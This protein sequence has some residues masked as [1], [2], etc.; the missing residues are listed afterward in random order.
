MW[1]VVRGHPHATCKTNE[2]TNVVST[3][4]QLT[5]QGGRPLRRAPATQLDVLNT[6]GGGSSKQPPSEIPGGW[7]SMSVHVHTAAGKGIGVELWGDTINEVQKVSSAATNLMVGDRITAVGGIPA[8]GM[9]K[10]QALLRDADGAT[11]LRIRRPTLANLDS[12]IAASL[13][14]AEAENIAATLQARA[15]GRGDGGQGVG[16]G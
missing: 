12:A 10:C 2:L 5:L 9:K 1:T 3:V 14:L 15:S 6:M 13:Q 16:I 7:Q 8:G 11:E 4:Q